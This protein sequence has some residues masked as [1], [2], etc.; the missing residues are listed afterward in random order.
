MSEYLLRLDDPSELLDTVTDNEI[1]YLT[2]LLDAAAQNNNWA[3]VGEL[4]TAQPGLVNVPLA[5]QFSVLHYAAKHG[6]IRPVSLLLSLKADLTLKTEEGKTPFDVAST[7]VVKCLLWQSPAPES[8]SSDNDGRE[9]CFIR[10]AQAMH[11]ANS[12]FV[13]CR[14]PNLTTKG[15]KQCE[16]ARSGWAAVVFEEAELI[17]VSPLRR[18]LQ[19][20]SFLN[21]QKN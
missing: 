9:V 5:G 8:M 21:G 19:T 18:A 10:H 13:E 1:E 4:L 12:R 11:N 15:F 14:D 2:E 20:V 6:D 17:V 16:A 7:D 3:K